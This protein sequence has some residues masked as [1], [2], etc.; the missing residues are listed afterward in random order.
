MT[1][2]EDPFFKSEAWLELRYRV[3]KESKGC[4]RV[5]GA[6]GSEVN[7][8]Q[9]DHI[10]PR[11]KFPELALVSGN[12]QVTCQKCNLG[13]SDKDQT[14]WRS[15]TTPIVTLEHADPT[16]KAR[17]QQLVWLKMKGETP[18]VRREAQKELDKLWS[19][20]TTDHYN[21]VRGE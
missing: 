7:P 11:S 1:A 5:C 4:C 12:L 18:E 14:D 17:Y 3:I 13:K 21:R 19:Q 8:I 15:G 20:V 2:N 10:K 9:V 16:T 6:R